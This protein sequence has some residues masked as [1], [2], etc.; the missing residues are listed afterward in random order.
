MFKEIPF[1][2][3]LVNKKGLQSYSQNMYV[4]PSLFE[5]ET[6]LSQTQNSQIPSDIGTV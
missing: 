1:K 3:T 5:D 6:K 4:I 2:H